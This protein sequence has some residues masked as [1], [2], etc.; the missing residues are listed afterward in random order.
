M[1]VQGKNNNGQVELNDFKMENKSR[2]SSAKTVNTWNC[3][4]SKDE[5]SRVNPL[6]GH[7]WTP[8][9]CKRWSTKRNCGQQDLKTFYNIIYK[10]W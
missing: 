1:Q 6:K 9:D 7:Q 2:H 4:Y 8:N 5:G 3:A 10:M